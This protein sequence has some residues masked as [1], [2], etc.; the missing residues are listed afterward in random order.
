MEF[1]YDEIDGDVM[2][3][4]AD[5]GLNAD[6]AEEFVTSIVKLIDAG[7]RKIIIDCSRLEYISSFGLGVLIR[8]HRRLG[9]CGGDVKLSNVRGMV[10]EVLQLTRLNRHVGIYP[11]VDAARLSFR[12]R[13][14][15]G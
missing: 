11:S 5:G 3:I 1:H 2:I 13:D 8:L 14:D 12:P 4:Q 15:G 6:T 7:L 10:P 9:E